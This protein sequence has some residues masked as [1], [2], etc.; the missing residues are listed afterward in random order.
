[1]SAP[2]DRPT[3]PCFAGCQP[4]LEPLVAQELQELGIV[5]RTL[6]GGVAFDGDVEAVMRAAHWLGCASHVLLRMAEF[7][8]R[9]LGELQRKAA[10]LPWADWL[11][12]GVPIAVRATA[13]RSRVYH[14]DAIVERVLEAITAALG[15][16]PKAARGDDEGAQL[17]VRFR[18]DVCTIS[19]DATTTPL[20]RRG[21]R[22]EGAKA[23]LREDIAHAVVRASGFGDGEALL[24][25]FCGSGT[26]A[27]EAA[28]FAQGLAPGRLRATPLAHLALFDADA[29]TRAQAVPRAPFAAAPIAAGDRDAGAI[30][31]A[32]ANADRA[33]VAAAIAFTTCA[34]TAH[35]WFQPGAAPTK[36]VVATNPPFG[37]RVGTGDLL[38]LYQSI[39]HRIGTL[40][41]GWRAAVLA[42]DVQLARRTALPLTAAFTTRHGGLSVSLLRTVGAAAVDPV[43]T[44]TP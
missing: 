24:D 40:G 7:P 25:P 26:I 8:C 5:G 41:P 6:A 17:L 33:G 20:H 3:R 14:T 31:A 16:P 37:K 43:P 4:G 23:P 29:W 21:Y 10:G 12:R 32:T 11:R 34:F 1:M 15:A 18:N 28:A 35:P 2:H 22:L 36:G 27:I 44:T 42:H 39:G 19:L 38:H 13:Q 30:A 9:A